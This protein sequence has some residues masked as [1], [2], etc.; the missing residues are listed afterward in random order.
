MELQ[1]IQ[2]KI[3]TIRGKK[4]MLD[5]DLAVFFMVETKRLKEAVRRNRKRF[6]P[7]F[8]FEL[9][10]EEYHSLRTQFASLEKKGKG[11]HAKYAPFAFTEHGISML[12][13][14]L[15]SDTAIDMHIAIMRAFTAMRQF[16]FHY[17]DLASQIMEIRES[18]SNHSQQLNLIYEA[19]ENILDNKAKQKTWE[20]REPIGFHRQETS[21]GSTV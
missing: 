9:T 6:P 8:M 13:G 20:N 7:D 15:T 10:S 5:F 17:N 14:V 11:G 21:T 18:V 3:F 2:Q 1:V 16:I 4:V 12:S 19:I